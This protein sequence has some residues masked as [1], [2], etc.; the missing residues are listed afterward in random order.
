M[1]NKVEYQLG[2][3]V[4]EPE[5]RVVHYFLLVCFQYSGCLLFKTNAT[6]LEKFCIKYSNF[7]DTVKGRAKQI[8]KT[9]IY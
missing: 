5:N 4:D 3:N 1:L 8:I 2:T 7:S 6:K 9:L